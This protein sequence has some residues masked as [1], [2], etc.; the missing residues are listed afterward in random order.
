MHDGIGAIIIED[1]KILLL[2]HNKIGKWVIPVGKVDVGEDTKTALA[3]ELF[4]ELDIKIKTYTTAFEGIIPHYKVESLNV[5]VAIYRIETYLGTIINKEPE[6]HKEI[7]FMSI[8]EILT[9]DKYNLVDKLT[10]Q[11][12]KLNLLK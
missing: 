3:R 5:L 11:L 4:E 9:L 10:I 1:N 2:Y 6:K 7:C 8:Q 12:L